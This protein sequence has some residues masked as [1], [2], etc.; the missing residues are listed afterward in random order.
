M[1]QEQLPMYNLSEPNNLIEPTDNQ[2]EPTNNHI[3]PTNN[4]NGPINNTHQYHY[5][6]EFGIQGSTLWGIFFIVIVLSYAYVLG[7]LAS[8]R[9]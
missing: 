1:I 8:A 9:H 4:Q 3:D 5:I 2:N 7:H 6:I